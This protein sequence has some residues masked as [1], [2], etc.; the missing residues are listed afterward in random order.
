[1]K[2]PWCS[3]EIGLPPP[4]RTVAKCV[5]CGGQLTY[6]FRGRT[7]L[8]ALVLTSVGAVVL[9]PYIGAEVVPALLLIPSFASVYLER[10][11]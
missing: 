2:C 3:R 6:A 5:Y 11:Y 8:I 4:G 9:F 1:M 7:A 10:W